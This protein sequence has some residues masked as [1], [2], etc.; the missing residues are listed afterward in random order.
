MIWVSLLVQNGLVLIS[1][2]LFALMF[3]N[4]WD[5]CGH[6]IIFGSLMVFVIL[7]GSISNLATVANT[8]SVEKDWVVVIADGNSKTLAGMV[9]YCSCLSKF[10]LH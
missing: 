1:T 5:V 10:A 2:V 7:S 9:I 8:I 4:Q 6:T 3:Y